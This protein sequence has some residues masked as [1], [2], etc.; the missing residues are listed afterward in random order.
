MKSAETLKQELIGASDRIDKQLDDVI[1]SAEDRERVS[2]AIKDEF[3]TLIVTIANMVF[4]KEKP[5][6]FQFQYRNGAY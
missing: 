6:R 5:E 4:E 1:N 2:A 3:R